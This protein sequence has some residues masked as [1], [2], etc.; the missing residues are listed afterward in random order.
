M[1]NK[2]PAILLTDDIEIAPEREKRSSA[3][4]T[5]ATNIARKLGCSIDLVH[6]EDYQFYPVSVPQ[7]KPMVES[8]F[9]TQQNKLTAA[10]NAFKVRTKPIFLNGEPVRKILSLAAKRDAYEM[11]VLGT[12]GRTGLSRLIL[13][14]VAEEVIRQAR[15]PVMTVG[16]KAQEKA[17]RVLSQSKVRILVPTGLT[18]NS[19]RAEEYSMSLAKRLDAEVVFFHSMREALHPVLQS[20]FTAPTASPQIRKFYEEVKGSAIKQL[21]KKA[22]AA[23]KKGVSATYVLDEKTSLSSDAILKEATRSESSLIVM[24]T[25]GRSLFA[26]AFFGRSVRGVILNAP[27][28]VVTVRSRKS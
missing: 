16:P 23:T 17:S 18:P 20:A 24:G 3:V 21:A 1:S 22:E 26:G 12:H 4:K 15:I 9:Q 10:A 25:H 5:C 14:S 8:Y 11:I 2:K 27:I 28:P 19:N 13:G 7:Y 6:V